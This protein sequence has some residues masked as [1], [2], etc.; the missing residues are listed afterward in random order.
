[1]S[2][3]SCRCVLRTIPPLDPRAVRA[4]ALQRRHVAFL[5]SVDSGSNSGRLSIYGFDPVRRLVC[6]GLDDPFAALERELNTHGPAAEAP[7]RVPLAGGWIGYFGYEAGR[8]I[9]PTAHWRPDAGPLPTACWGL[10]DTLLIHDRNAE[11]WRIAALDWRDDLVSRRPP[12]EVRLDELAAFLGGLEPLAP[13]PE[14]RGVESPR[15][16]M[17]KGEYISRIERALAYIRAGDIFQ[18]NIAQQCRMTWGRHPVDLYDRLCTTNPAAYAAY[19]QVD[20]SGTGLPSAV[21]SSSPELFLA[22]RGRRVVTRPIKGT[23][24]RTGDAPADA[25]AVAELAASEKDRAELNMIIDLERN[26]LGRVCAYGTVRV[27]D[28]GAIETHPTVFHR[29]ATVSGELRPG[30]GAMELVRATFPGGSITGAPKVRA[31]QIIRELEP[32]ARGPYCGSIGYV[33]VNGEMQLN[34]AIRTMTLAEGVATLS[35][36]G[37]IVVDSDPEEEYAETLAK[38]RGMLAAFGS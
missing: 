2:T 3:P 17:T 26:D 34:I 13:S 35:V 38:A 36:G 15:W 25:R 18:V 8:F 22:L 7:D 9:E 1:M 12:A 24:P 32:D 4:A 37:G 14:L 27:E 11:E 16:N 19:I 29:T 31:M 21:V 30:V 20:H 23:R 5:E 6:K 10:Y 28:A 33:G